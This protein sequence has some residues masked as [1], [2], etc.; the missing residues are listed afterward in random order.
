MS[1]KTQE[2]LLEGVQK[3][4]LR[5]LSRLISW[6]ENREP[7][8]EAVLAKLYSK[9]GK[10]RVFGITGPP[11]AG[12][13][14]LV[15][16][17]IRLC[18]EKGEKVAVVAVDPVS[19]FTGGA[20][21]GDRIRLSEHFNDPGVFIRSLSTRGK[22]GGLSLATR[23]VVHFLD[24]FGFD[25]ILLETVGVGQSEVEVR[26]IA[27][28]TLVVLVPEWGDGVQ[29][30]KSGILE[31]GDVFAVHKADREG[32]D[33]IAGELRQAL[34]EL[35]PTPSVLLSEEKKPESVAALLQALR[36]FTEA[37]AAKVA[38][39]RQAARAATLAELVESRVLEQ[40]RQ[41]V[42]AHTAAAANPYDGF[43]KFDAAQTPWKA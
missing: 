16:H 34:S 39:R 17:F 18:R 9:I 12:K 36:D 25:T 27:D 26:K 21:L 33:R 19:P 41:W 43:L 4:D 2:Q 22:L 24:A 7:G 29:A 30:L 38:G 13:S 14:T 11:G 8:T 37:Q 40:A 23:E 28:A 10:A 15:G 5:A 32:A 6:A 35:K 3:G 20:L 1:A 31:I 42:A